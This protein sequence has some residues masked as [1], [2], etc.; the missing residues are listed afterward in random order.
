MELR[1][2]H[3]S[4][5]STPITTRQLES[6]IR[7]SEARARCEMRQIVTSNDAADVIEL[8]RKSLF[9][10]YQTDFGTLDFGRSQF[11][12]GIYRECY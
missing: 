12:T 10:G 5:D 11:G 3:R 1:R 9:D 4:L 2:N 7:L 8:M 6:M